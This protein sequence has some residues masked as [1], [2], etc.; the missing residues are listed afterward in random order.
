MKTN[1]K[2]TIFHRTIVSLSPIYTKFVVKEAMW[3]GGHG[4]ALN[5][6][7]VEGNDLKC[8]IPYENDNLK[9]VH[10]DIGDYIVKGEIMT[11]IASKRDLGSYDYYTITSLEERDYGSESMRH[12]QIGAK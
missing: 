3:Q 10:V 12:L 11:N 7:I 4:S 8:Y 1:T 5:K 9:N 2:I 6:G